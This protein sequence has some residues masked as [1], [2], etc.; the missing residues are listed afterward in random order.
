MTKTAIYNEL[1][2][3]NSLAWENDDLM[4]QETLFDLQERLADLLLRV[5]QDC[6]EKTLN[7][8]VKSFPFLY[9]VR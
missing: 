2:K 6:G 8:L 4:E 1:K 7:D 5:A 9:G 3:L